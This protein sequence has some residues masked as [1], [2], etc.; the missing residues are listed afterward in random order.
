MTYY[1]LTS[2]RSLERFLKGHHQQARWCGLEK[3]PSYRTFTRRFH[4]LEGPLQEASRALIR[5]LAT[6]GLVNLKITALDSSL[7]EAKGRSQPKKRPDI[8]PGDRDARW[9]YSL[10][11]G[12]VWGYKIHLLSTT[13][14]TPLP[15]GWITTT[16]NLQDISFASAVLGNGFSRLTTLTNQMVHV[17]ADKAYDAD[18]LWV[19]TREHQLT[20]TAH[21][22]RV[23]RKNPHSKRYQPS[24]YCILRR[25]WR[26]CPTA[27]KVLKERT[28][29]EHLYAALKRHFS[30]ILYPLKVSVRSRFG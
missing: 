30:W 12:W 5:R 24:R 17:G 22:K 21:I 18:S 8:H 6:Y 29:I 11:R 20:L 25:Q 14:P 9:G 26:R 7:L 10:L 28:R 16:A 19:W 1:H 2:I 27:C 23:K 3:V 13:S 4:T 15:V